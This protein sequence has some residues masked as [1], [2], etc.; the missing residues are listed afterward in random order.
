MQMRYRSR[1]RRRELETASGE[2][3]GGSAR[4]RCNRGRGYGAHLATARC[5]WG[6]GARGEGAQDEARRKVRMVDGHD[7]VAQR[8]MGGTSGQEGPSKPAQSTQQMGAVQQGPG[9]GRGGAERSGRRRGGFLGEV[10]LAAVLWRL[11][12]PCGCSAVD[13]RAATMTPATLAVGRRRVAC[14]QDP[15]SRRADSRRLAACRLGTSRGGAFPDGR[16]VHLRTRAERR[17]RP[18]GATAHRQPTRPPSMILRSTAARRGK[19]HVPAG[20]PLSVSPLTAVA[21]APTLAKTSSRTLRRFLS[22]DATTPNAAVQGSLS[23]AVSAPDAVAEQFHLYKQQGRPALLP[24]S[25]RRPPI[26]TSCSEADAQA[27]LRHQP[28]LPAACP[29]QPPA[30]AC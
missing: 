1:D 23:P 19:H 8:Q 20:F 22:T 28:P 7:G 18:S 17:G 26:L 30:V 27:G 9:A 13:R 2:R 3:G 10:T 24:P 11:Q 4:A 21:A 12:S 14:N 25:L 15:G 6:A 5:G 16:C 29:P